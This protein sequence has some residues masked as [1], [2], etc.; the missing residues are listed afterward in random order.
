M[1]E[2]VKIR[3]HLIPFLYK[4]CTGKEACYA[5][6]S[7]LS[8]RFFPSSSVAR[9]LYNLVGYKKKYGSQDVY[10]LF[11]EVEKENFK[12][13]AT[14]YVEDTGVKYPALLTSEQIRDFNSLLEDMFRL[15]FIFFV[16]GCIE[17]GGTIQDGITKFIEK[18]ELLEFGFD[19]EALRALYK[20][21]KKTEKISRFQ[22]QSSNRVYNY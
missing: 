8:A 21:A 4:E 1:K 15:S 14:L 13:K 10:F 20:R 19:D 3:Q 11:I 17:A 16:D 12:Y 2:K 7:V 9:Y 22:N 6:K 18:Y 5:G